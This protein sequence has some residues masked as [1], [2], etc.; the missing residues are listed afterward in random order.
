VCILAAFIFTVNCPED[1]MECCVS[2]PLKSLGSAYQIFLASCAG[3]FSIYRAP[4][5]LIYVL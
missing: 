1:F 4:P 2:H 5:N 3:V